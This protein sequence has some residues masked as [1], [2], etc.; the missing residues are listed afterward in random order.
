MF[1]TGDAR[2]CIS[3]RVGRE[4]VATAVVCRRCTRL[5]T[6]ASMSNVEEERRFHELLC[7]GLT[8][9]MF[10]SFVALTVFNCRLKREE[11]FDQLSFV[12]TPTS[13]TNQ[14]RE[15]TVR[16]IRRVVAVHGTS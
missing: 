11:R 7:A 4:F 2:V 1:F 8:C 6:Q 15:S 5:L 12:Q 3:R 16:K 10:A 9:S 13:L 14:H